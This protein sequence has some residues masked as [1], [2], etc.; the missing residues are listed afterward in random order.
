MKRRV[1]V[2]GLLCASI[3]IGFGQSL[4]EK[5]VRLFILAGQSNMDGC[6]LA[7]E[8]PKKYQTRLEWV[9]VWDNTLK[10]WVALAET[11]FSIRR[12]HQFGPEMAFAH[13]L[14]KAYP[15]QRIALIKTSGGG[16]TLFMHWLPDSVMYRRC[17]ENIHNAMD[18]LTE[19]NQPY[20]MCGMLWMQGESDSETPEMANAYE[21][22]LRLLFAALRK[23]MK[24]PD[25]PIVMGRISSSLLKE[26]PWVFDQAKIVQRAQEIVA[27]DDPSV[28]IIHTDRL[29]TLPDNTH[30][31]TRA[32]LKLGSKMARIMLNQM[33]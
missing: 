12:D 10:K 8:L 20:E 23:E 27:K 16:T 11:T 18:H 5:P 26:T 33:K 17:L 14:A 4:K 29:S 31:D 2:I 13:R 7:K 15:D 3:T 9:T 1:L 19:A 21:E 24:K 28:F 30:F 22:N 6:G 32:Q 25:L